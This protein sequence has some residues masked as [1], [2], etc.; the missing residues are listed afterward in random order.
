[1]FVSILKGQIAISPS[2]I[3]KTVDTRL[4]RISML[5]EMSAMIIFSPLPKGRGSR[6]QSIPHTFRETLFP[7][8]KPHPLVG[9]AVDSS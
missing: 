7:S 9:G 4:T 8:Y 5:P 1:M 3:A 2:S 6:G